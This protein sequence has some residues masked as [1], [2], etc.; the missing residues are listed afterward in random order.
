MS[1]PL[2]VP[3]TP[4]KKLKSNPLQDLLGD[5]FVTKV[6]PGKPVIELVEMEVTN[7]KSETLIELKSDPLEWWCQN[8]KKYP[9]MARAAKKYLCIQATSVAS[10][11]IFSVAGDIVSKQRASL[12]A[13]NVDILIFLKKNLQIKDL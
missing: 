10:E 12:T 13:E 11:R 5:V 1:K 9:L 6:E 2:D 3:E 7:Y 8:E 4:P